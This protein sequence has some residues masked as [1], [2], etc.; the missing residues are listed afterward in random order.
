MWITELRVLNSLPVSAGDRAEFVALM[1]SSVSIE[2]SVLWP[3]NS[4]LVSKN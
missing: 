3:K 2:E 4:I 1:F